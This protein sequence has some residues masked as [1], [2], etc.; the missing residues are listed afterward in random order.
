MNAHKNAVA[1]AIC[2]IGA[3]CKRSIL[4]AIASEQSFESLRMN[5]AAHPLRDI[6]RQILFE[7]SGSDCAGIDS[8]VAGIDHNHGNAFCWAR[9]LAY[10]HRLVRCREKLQ[11]DD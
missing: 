1:L 2:E 9:R 10:C 4:I 8:T 11:P 6:E 7:H 5:N 3:V